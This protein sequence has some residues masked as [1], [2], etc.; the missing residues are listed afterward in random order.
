MPKLPDADALA[1]LERRI[2]H[3]FADRSRLIRA[4]T[5]RSASP[6]NMERFEFLGDAVLGLVI[7]EALHAREPEADEGRL[8]RLRALLV[9]RESLGEVAA[10]WALADCLIV[11][12][13][14]RVNGRLRSPSIAANAVEAVIGAVFE[15]AGFDAAREVVLAAWSPWLSRTHELETRDAKTRLQEYTQARGWGLPVYR[16]EDGGDRASP[17]FRAECEVRGRVAGRGAG[18]RRKQAEARAAERALAALEA[19]E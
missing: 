17:R 11:G 5:H 7:A 9:R 15:D 6:V 12:K 18:E 8:S 3:R 4:L 13:G 16:V 10:G 1:A 14:E 2:G 19:D